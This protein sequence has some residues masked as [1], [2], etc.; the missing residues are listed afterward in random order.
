MNKLDYLC[1]D[2]STHDF[3]KDLGL[4]SFYKSYKTK[5][6]DLSKYQNHPLLQNYHLLTDKKNLNISKT[7]IKYVSAQKIH[8]PII[9]NKYIKS[10]GILIGHGKMYGKKF[11]HL[12]DP[13]K[14]T[15]LLLKFDPSM[16]VKSDNIIKIEPRIFVIKMSNYYI[17]YRHYTKSHRDILKEK[18]EV[19]LK[20]KYGNIV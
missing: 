10:G 2:N 20:D 12:D 19:I 13:T 18:I 3:F 5:N 6:L 1:S 15:H 17:Y 4:E 7:Y 16:M 11:I 14:S 9:K 8:R